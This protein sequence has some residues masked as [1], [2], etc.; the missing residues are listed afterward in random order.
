MSKI[1]SVR[2]KLNLS[3][4]YWFMEAKIVFCVCYGPPKW[5]KYHLDT[6]QTTLSENNYYYRA[7]FVRI[8]FFH[9]WKCIILGGICRSKFWHLR[10]KPAVV[11]S[12]FFKKKSLGMSWAIWS[13]KIQV[14]E[15]VQFLNFLL[16]KKL[17]SILRTFQVP[18]LYVGVKFQLFQKRK[19]LVRGW[20]CM[21][22]WVSI[23]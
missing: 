1:N 22:K 10:R 12:N 14:K 17:Y 7:L 6:I 21:V 5:S 9:A 19:A 4:K 11:F 23:T 15:L 8:N 20:S 2:N 13:G 18:T 3:F 16:N